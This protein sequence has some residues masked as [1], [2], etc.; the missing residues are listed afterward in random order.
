[1]QYILTRRIRH[2][3]TVQRDLTDVL[4][5]LMSIVPRST[6]T[7]PRT[8]HTE[9]RSTHTV[10]RQGQTGKGTE[11]Y[12]CAADER[13]DRQGA[14]SIGLLVSRTLWRLFNTVG[15]GQE[16][17]SRD[18][19]RRETEFRA[20]VAAY[21]RVDVCQLGR[22]ARDGCCTN[23]SFQRADDHYVSTFGRRGSV[24]AFG[25]AVV[26]KREG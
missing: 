22:A 25:A 13:R 23:G 10:R 7:E 14:T 21:V 3:D 17:I 15:S 1:M 19:T 4:V 24:G 11:R 20:L 26:R 2:K 12:S 5:G 16:G 6:R 8:T 18:E 9:P